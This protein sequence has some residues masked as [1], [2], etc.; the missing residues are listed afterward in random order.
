MDLEILEQHKKIYIEAS[1]ELI[2]NNTRSL[3]EDDIL[4]LFATP[5]LETMDTIKQRLLSL[6]KTYHLICDTSQLD[7]CLINYREYLRKNLLKISEIRSSQLIDK[8]I[9]FDYNDKEQILK[10]LKKELIKLDKSIKK[11]V[12]T[13]LKT[14]NQKYLLDNLKK[15][16]TTGDNTNE[17]IK[18]MTKFLQNGYIKQQLELLDMKLLVKDTTLISGLRE[19]IER[20]VF[21]TENSHLFD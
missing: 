1:K 15:L 10:E 5:P 4:P 18:D 12:K 11:E 14:A 6:A 7:E 8:V 20:F 17:F 16:I 19:Q 2:I 13:H 3:I 21:T 9:L